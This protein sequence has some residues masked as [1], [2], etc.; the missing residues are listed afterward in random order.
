MTLLGY[1]AS[2]RARTPTVA[3]GLYMG[4]HMGMPMRGLPRGRFLVL[5]VSYVSRH[6][7]GRHATPQSGTLRTAPAFGSGPSFL[8]HHHY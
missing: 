5:P 1:K 7:Y 3:M 2:D 8:S 4:T 6:G